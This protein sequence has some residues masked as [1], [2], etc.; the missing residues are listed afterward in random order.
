MSRPD[1]GP[2]GHKAGRSVH[3]EDLGGDQVEGIQAVAELLRAG[4]RPVSELLVAAGD[5]P[6]AA[7][8]EVVDLARGQRVPV[9][10]CTT[11][12]LLRVAGTEA[13]QGVVARTQRVRPVP[14]EDLVVDSH[15]FLLALDGVTDPQ[16]LGALLRTAL[17]AGVT[18]V[19][20]PRHHAVRLTPSAV[21][22]AA[23][24]VEHLP[25]ALVAGIPAALAQLRRDGV[26]GVGLDE[27]G[28]VE[29]E[30]VAVLS[31]PVVLVLGAE[32]PGISALARQRCDVLARIELAGPL[33]SL[34]V[35][36]AGAVACF[37][38]ARRRRQATG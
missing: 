1:R 15:P 11:A 9:R 5:T 31:E 22:A 33:A 12:E 36:A 7:L 17:S 10:Q 27:R 29:I 2:R 3:G 20:L 38:V 14:L 28:D 34:N 30:D 19:V 25:I 4:R 6:S 37:A 24:A 8:R 13:P 16:N 26:W 18:G 32:G 21:K 35:S 23:G